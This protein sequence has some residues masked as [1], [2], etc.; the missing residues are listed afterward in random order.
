MDTKG[1]YTRLGRTIRTLLEVRC[2]T[3]GH[4]LVGTVILGFL[5]IYKNRHAS[6]TFEALNSACHSR[7]QKDVRPPVEMRGRLALS[8][9]SLE[10]FRNPFIL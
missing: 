2:E 4:S 5:T 8:V 6:S 9:G 1:I 7:F 10:G 3:M